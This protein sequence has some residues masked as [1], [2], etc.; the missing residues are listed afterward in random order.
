M[1]NPNKENGNTVISMLPGGGEDF[2]Q[3]YSDVSQLAAAQN[4]EIERLSKIVS[5]REL[6][7]A[8]LKELLFKHVPELGSTMHVSDEEL[9]A[10]VQLERLKNKAMVTTLS[11]EEIKIFDLLV[12]NKRL[13]EGKSTVNTDSTK[14]PDNMSSKDLSKIA[15]KHTSVQKLENKDSKNE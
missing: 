3:K 14:L 15:Q 8:H 2:K 9:V 13:A 5:E 10:R 7:I 1:K 12:K 4:V 11:L 6:E